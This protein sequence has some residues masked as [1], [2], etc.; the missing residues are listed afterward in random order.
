MFLTTLYLT[1]QRVTAVDTNTKTAVFRNMT[2][3]SLVN[4]YHLLGW[5]YCF[6]LHH[7][8]TC[9]VFRNVG[10]IPP[11]YTV[12][13][14]RKERSYYSAQ[15]K[16]HF[17]AP[18]FRTFDAA[19]PGTKVPAACTNIITNG[20]WSHGKNGEDLPVLTYAPRHED[21]GGSDGGPIAPCILN[22]GTTWAWVYKPR[23]FYPPYPLDRRLGGPQSRSGCA[24]DGTNLKSLFFLALSPIRRLSHPVVR[25]VYWSKVSRQPAMHSE[26]T[27][28]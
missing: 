25:S 10:E 20:E 13:D 21:T 4:V 27:L 26:W 7:R 17:V 28:T 22:L 12:S 1:F 9:Y 11:V 3:C 2:P 19:V 23:P 5:T 15:K 8:S 24:R 18:D 14:A 16:T 6:H